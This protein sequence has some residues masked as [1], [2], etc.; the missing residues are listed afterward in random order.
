MERSVILDEIKKIICHVLNFEESTI[1]WNY[2][3]NMINSFDIDSILLVDLLIALDASPKIC[4]DIQQLTNDDLESINSL[5]D[6][7]IN[8]Q[9][10]H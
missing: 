6:Y 5:V 10:K 9:D 2:N 3:A 4:I 8:N 7:I 1:S